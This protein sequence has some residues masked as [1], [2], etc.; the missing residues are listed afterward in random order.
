MTTAIGIAVLAA[1]FLAFPFIKRERAA[2]CG[3]GDSGCWKK[4]VGF[5]CGDCPVDHRRLHRE[6][7]AEP[8]RPI[9]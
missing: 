9:L 4:K 6:S 2:G 8:D 5:G 7:G 3:S 1:L